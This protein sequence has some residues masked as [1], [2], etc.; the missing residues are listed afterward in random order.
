MLP[1]TIA[2]MAVLLSESWETGGWISTWGL[3][4]YPKMTAKQLW[5][6]A[7]LCRS[8]SA[9]RTGCDA[10]VDIVGQNYCAAFPLCSTTRCR[11][12]IF[13]SPFSF[14]FNTHLYQ[15]SQALGVGWIWTGNGAWMGS[16][17]RM[18]VFQDMKPRDSLSLV[19]LFLSLPSTPLLS[20]LPQHQFSQQALLIPKSCDSSVPPSW[21]SC[22][23]SKMII[24][25]GKL[26]QTS[27]L[28]R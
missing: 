4:L 28:G 21:P 15:G 19:T 9:E 6:R 23:K 13:L 8:L 5:L 18:H 14:S 26:C 10:E 24:C 25:F 27:Y 20:L 11:E 12:G 7:V 17:L 1:S 3:L 22:L 16:D 2:K